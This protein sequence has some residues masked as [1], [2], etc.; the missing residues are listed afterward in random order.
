VESARAAYDRLATIYDECNAQNDYEMW[1]GEALLPELEMRGLR[2]DW[3][4]DAGCGTGRA[5]NPLLSRGWRIVGCDVSAGMLEEARRKFGSRVDL[6][7]VDA[8]AI[9]PICP[10][11][12]LPTEQAF[13]LVLLLNDVLNYMTEDDDLDKAFA[14]VRRNLSRDHGLVL[15]D[16]NTLSLYRAGFTTGVSQEMS[17][18]GLEWRGLTE[19][20][21]PG[22][23]YEAQV[24]G[25]GVDSHFHR[26]RHWTIE[27]VE[28]ALE[29][30]GLSCLAVLGQREEDGKVLLTNPPDEERDYKIIFIAGHS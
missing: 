2:K 27:Q 3:V 11:P 10:A 14:G 8:R 22:A 12:G 30:A 26:Q 19:R 17:A 13:Q 23:V 29:A 7:N 16:V 15:F 4:L 28:R 9:P 18:R 24:S 5:F 1:L 21:E 6:L 25:P 20:V